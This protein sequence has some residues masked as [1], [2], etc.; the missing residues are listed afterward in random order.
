M[1]ALEVEGV[2]PK[3][4]E[5]DLTP[6]LGVGCGCWFGL[7]SWSWWPGWANGLEAAA[8]IRGVLQI[9]GRRE[10]GDDRLSMAD[11]GDYRVD[12]G[13]CSATQRART[14]VVAVAA[15]GAAVE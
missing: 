1:E 15:V 9:L 3:A 4:G 8:W 10:G 2:A 14:R 12:V 13:R 6:D 5:C 11:L 7:A